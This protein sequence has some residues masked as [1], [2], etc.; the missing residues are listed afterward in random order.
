MTMDW[1]DEI[2]VELCEHDDDVC[3]WDQAGA[4]AKAL[5][6]AKADGMR[7]AAEIAELGIKYIQESGLKGGEPNADESASRQAGERIREAANLIDKPAE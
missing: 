3:L 6:K 5:R 4:I 7:E 1:A 2:G